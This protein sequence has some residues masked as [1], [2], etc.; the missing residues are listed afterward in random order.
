MSGPYLFI[1]NY[2]LSVFTVGIGRLQ[3]EFHYVILVLFFIVEKWW[4]V[5]LNSFIEFLT[6]F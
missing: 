2:V 1:R 5:S 6:S 4:N 3:V